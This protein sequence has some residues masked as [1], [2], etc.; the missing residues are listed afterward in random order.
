MADLCRA[1]LSLPKR[2]LNPV[3]GM[4][5]IVTSRKNP[6]ISCIVPVYNSERYLAE[7]L[8]SILAQ[9]YQPI[10]IIVID[11]GSTDA[12]AAIVKKFGKGIRYQRQANAGPPAARDEGVRLSTG[13]FVAFLDADDIW[14]SEKLFRQWTRFEVRNELDLCLTHVQ[15]F[16][17]PEMEEEAQRF[18]G[19][20][21][22]KRLPA[23]IAP[24]LL[25]RRRL[26]Q[27]VGPFNTGH[28]F[29]DVQDWIL[30]AAEQGAVMEMLPE[31]LW[32][33]RM[34]RTNSSMEASTRQMNGKM[35]E[36][37]LQIIRASLL[38][39]RAKNRAFPPAYRLPSSN[40]KTADGALGEREKDPPST[41]PQSE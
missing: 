22:S 35:E 12:S 40:W 3:A 18:Q 15:H 16:W 25:V 14:H 39:R 20:R 23:F 36:A 21:L 5:S 37:L 24:S 19:H 41:F 38:R 17:V 10:E 2:E 7:A 34:H 29:A 32:F 11:D 13:E 8:E 4:A 27:R 26:F 9:S 31:A 30:R 1:K 6:T 33:R 28:K